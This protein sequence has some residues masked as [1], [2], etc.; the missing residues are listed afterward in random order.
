MLPNNMEQAQPFTITSTDNAKR[1][2][3]ELTEDVIDTDEKCIKVLNEFAERNSSRLGSEDLA[4]LQKCCNTCT[5]SVDDDVDF[6]PADFVKL[7][8]MSTQFPA[9][10]DMLM[11][12]MHHILHS[13]DFDGDELPPDFNLY[14]ALAHRALGDA[15]HNTV[16]DEDDDDYEE[17]VTQLR[18][19]GYNGSLLE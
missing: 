16:G 9:D 2:Y 5:A 3:L 1:E 8:F 14:A 17:A 10:T 11:A 7:G 6:G 19:N 12:C 4:L 13:L 18:A 15:Y